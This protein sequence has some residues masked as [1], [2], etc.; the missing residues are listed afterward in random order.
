MTNPNYVQEILRAADSAE[1]AVERT[2]AELEAARIRFRIE[3]LKYKALRDAAL[4][5]YANPLE[6]PYLRTLDTAVWGSMRPNRGR[7]RFLAMS[8]SDAVVLALA[9][10][11]DDRTAVTIT[12]LQERI[13]DGSDRQPELRAVNAAV[14]GL[15]SSGAAIKVETEDGQTAYRINRVKFEDPDDLP[16]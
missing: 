10:M 8:V 6:N 16:F 12:G 3:G 1:E 11:T 13:R 14:Q 5:Y 9:E 7:F 2:H 4:A 15:V